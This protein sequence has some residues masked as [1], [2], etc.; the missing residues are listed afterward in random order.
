MLDAVVLGVIAC[1]IGLVLGEELSIHLF[2]SN[3]GYLSSAFAVGSQ[4]VVGW[5]SVAIAVPAAWSRQASR[6]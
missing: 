3:P 5:Q 4:R 1:A 2:R 6:C